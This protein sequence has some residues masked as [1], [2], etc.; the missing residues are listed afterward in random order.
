MSLAIA[1]LAWSLLLPA[2]LLLRRPP[3]VAGDGAA[4]GARAAADPGTTVGQAL[5]SVPF[6]VLALTFFCCCAAHCGPIFHTVSYAI[7]CGLGP[8]AAVSIYS[9]EGLAGL[10]GRLLFGLAGDRL[11]ARPVLVVGLMIQALAAGSYYVT[12]Q[13]GAFYAVALVFGHWQRKVLTIDFT[14]KISS[15]SP[16]LTACPSPPSNREA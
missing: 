1:V 12:R 4:T 15:R 14:L 9:A 16:I 11:G 6:V 7:A 10:G 13:L 8:M 3:P 2:A 5:R